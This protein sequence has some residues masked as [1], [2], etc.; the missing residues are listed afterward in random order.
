MDVDHHVPARPAERAGQLRANAPG[1]TGDED[2]R[3]AHAPSLCGAG[4]VSSSQAEEV[5]SA[6]AGL[7]AF[8]L[9]AEQRA[10]NP[11]DHHA[12]GAFAPGI[13]RTAQQHA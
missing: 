4:G 8:D 9:A 12:G 13:D 1:G 3:A 11:A 10:G 6:A 5:R 2:G 7:A